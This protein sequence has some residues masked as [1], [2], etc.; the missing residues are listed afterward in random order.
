VTKAKLRRS[1]SIARCA[2]RLACDEGD[3]PQATVENYDHD[4]VSP[5]PDDANF[6]AAAIA[7]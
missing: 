6:F 4:N 2:A 3:K 5:R 7:L 1:I